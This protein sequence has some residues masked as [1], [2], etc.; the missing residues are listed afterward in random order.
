MYIIANV[1]SLSSPLLDL[2][3]DFM[4]FMAENNISDEQLI[5]GMHNNILKAVFT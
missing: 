1:E 5:T 2:K 3:Y 4:R